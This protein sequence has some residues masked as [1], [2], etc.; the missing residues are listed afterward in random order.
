ME[1]RKVSLEKIYQILDSVTKKDFALLPKIKG[2][3]KTLNNLLQEAKKELSEELTKQLEILIKGLDEV[4]LEEK[5][6]RLLKMK[7]IFLHNNLTSPCPVSE[8]LSQKIS[9]SFEIEDIPN[10]ET[11]RNHRTI[12][13]QKIDL[14]KGIGPKIAKKFQKK[15]IETIED[16]L[17]FL[18]R[19]YEDRRKITPIGELIEEKTA[20]VFGEIIKSGVNYYSKRKTYEI[21]M[22]DG[23][24]FLTLKWFN[25]Q[26]RV[27]RGLY[28]PGKKIY[29][30][31][32]VH[33]FLK[34]LEMIHPETFSEEEE[35]KLE[36]ELGRIVP[37]YSAIEG[38]PEKTLKKIM[39]S[40]V[41]EY[42]DLVDNLIPPHILKKANLLP[43]KEALRNLHLPQTSENFEDLL[44]ERNIYLRSL[45]FEELFFLELGLA[46]K[47][48]QVVKEKGIAFRVESPLVEEFL[49]RL[50]F[51]LTKAQRR[52][53]EEIKKD[54]AK[55]TPMNRLIQGDVGCGKTVVAFVSALIA[56]DNG[57]QVALMAPTEILAEQHYRNFRAYAQ[58]MGIPFCLLTGGISPAKKREIYHG[59][60]TGYY[61]LVIGT[62]ALFQERVE[63]KKLGLVIIDEQHRFGVL[64]RA[65]LREKAKGMTPDTL[66]MTATPIPRT[67]ALT[68]YGDL[69]VSIIDEMPKGRKPV[70]TKLFLEYNKDKAYALVR[71]EL[72]RG[73]QAYVI[74]PLIEESESLNLK[75]VMTYGEELQREVFPEFR[76]KILHGKMSSI[77]KD[78]IM[79]AFK[80]GEINVLVSTTVV[81]VGVDVPN[82]TVMVIEHAE[83]FGLSQLH[84]LRGRVGRSEKQSYCFLIAYNVSFQS[85]AFKRLQILTQTYDGFKI[86]EED[87]KL[88]GPGDL[89]G[90]QQSGFIEFK[91]ADPV[92]DLDLLLLARDSAF[93][94]IREDPELK[95]YPALREE[96]FRRWEERLK[97]SEVA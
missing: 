94:L 74:L 76:V 3:E 20:V 62:H 1:Q 67:L 31:G 6:L 7:E 9:P 95:K 13:S 60:A 78:K 15:G 84:Q 8:A 61:K 69:D 54:M 36:T 43:V 11:Y 90:T 19:T 58:L 66:V 21:L 4:N 64:Q 5:K 73:N 75:A 45:S 83:R 29:A 18:P 48:S 12:L 16:L 52:V 49:K 87:L 26:E 10:P 55:P 2:L 46:L 53:I 30:I 44:N 65:A 22:T 25:F 96:L 59:L 56:I 51:E 38:L 32:E 81:E 35:E 39:R 63:F 42:V 89:F 50:P 40:V 47:K 33:R 85:E 72:K 57:Y 80:R 23:T 92:R 77:E 82:A 68:V 24:G 93:E 27:M 97:L 70:I 17:F 34:T 41:E 88:R 37:V 14:I 71:E 91:R 28:P 79:Q 86:A